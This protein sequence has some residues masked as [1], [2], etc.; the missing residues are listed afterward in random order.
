MDPVKLAVTGATGATGREIVRAATARGHDV[1]AIARDPAKAAGLSAARL[2][3]CDL[4]VAGPEELSEIFS[5]HDA[6]INAAGTLADGPAYVPLVQRV[7]RAAADALGPG[8]RFWL[9]GG[10]GLLTVPGTDITTLDLP[11]MP[12]LF[13]AHRTNLHT[14]AASDLDWSMLCP[15]P[16][17]HAPD[18][19]PTDGLVIAADVWPVKRPALAAFAPRPALVLAFRMALPQITIYYE[20]AAHVIIAHLERNSPLSRRRVGIALPHGQKRY[21]KAA[22]PVSR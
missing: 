3:I 14:V 6:V 19:R 20:D 5:G 9:M 17:I 2:R 4:S 8:G 15:G 10:A 21:K 13:E 11:G 18:G 12:K 7:I 22:R 1:T 16:M